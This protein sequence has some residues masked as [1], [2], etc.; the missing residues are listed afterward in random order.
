MRGTV[1]YDRLGDSWQSTGNTQRL[2]AFAKLVGAEHADANGWAT[3]R[4]QADLRVF[5]GNEGQMLAGYDLYGF[6]LTQMKGQYAAREAS[7][8][9]S[10]AS[11]DAA[12]QRLGGKGSGPCVD[13]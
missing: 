1:N 5:Q 13:R 9:A 6:L 8:R 2:L 10:L 12:R 4:H 7:L 11:A 3:V